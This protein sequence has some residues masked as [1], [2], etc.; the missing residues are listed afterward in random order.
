MQATRPMLQKL[1][2][3]IADDD[4]ETQVS[5]IYQLMAD[6]YKESRK[7]AKIMRQKVEAMKRKKAMDNIYGRGQLTA[8]QLVVLANRN[9]SL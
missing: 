9:L 3:T 1:E 2:V 8:R 4:L 7:R 5:E 6:E